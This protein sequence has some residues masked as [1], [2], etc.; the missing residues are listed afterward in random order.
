MQIPGAEPQGGNTPPQADGDSSRAAGDGLDSAITLFD[1]EAVDAQTLFNQMRDLANAIDANIHRKDW[2][3]NYDF[4]DMMNDDFKKHPIFMLILVPLTIPAFIGWWLSYMA[5]S[6][7]RGPDY[8]L[9]PIIMREQIDGAHLLMKTA[10]SQMARV[11]GEDQNLLK[12]GKALLA[13]QL[14]D[15]EEIINE[16]SGRSD[17]INVCFEKNPLPFKNEGVAV[18]A[19]I[20]V[21][22]PAASLLPQFPALAGIVLFLPQSLFPIID[23]L[24]AVSVF[25]LD[26]ALLLSM[27]IWGAALFGVYRYYRPH[28]PALYA[29]TWIGRHIFSSVALTLCLLVFFFADTL[30]V[31]L[32]YLFRDSLI[33]FPPLVIAVLGFTLFTGEVIGEMLR[34]VKFEIIPRLF[35]KKNDGR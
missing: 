6:Y 18:L 13:E 33:V 15:V 1:D 26:T 32:I 12:R 8:S 19:V 30:K 28:F 23:Q 24:A 29:K 14:H 10:D 17:Y 34:T 2:P 22:W 3:D 27:T 31:W 9:P 4:V 5:T 25:P 16:V 35:K 21:V 7:F 11:G 20:G